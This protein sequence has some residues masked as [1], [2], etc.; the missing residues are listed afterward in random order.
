MN[1]AQEFVIMAMLGGILNTIGS[2][3]GAFIVSWLPEMLRFSTSWMNIIY[4]VMVVILMIFMPMG[5]SSIVTQSVKRIRRGLRA[6]RTNRTKEEK[7]NVMSE[8]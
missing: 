8:G 1:I 6:K 5:L 7:N 3:V 2:F 4:G